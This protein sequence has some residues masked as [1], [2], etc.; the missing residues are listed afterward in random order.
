MA[1]KLATAFVDFVARMS[2]FDKGIKEV[3][4]D[5]SRFMSRFQALGS[6]FGISLGIG[7]AVAASY[8]FIEAA[9]E[10][11]EVETRMR[12]VLK[13]TG[14]AAGFNA[15]QILKMVGAL[16]QT[17]V[18]GDEALIGAATNLMKF[19]RVAGD[20]FERAL[21][22]STDLAATGFGSVEAASQ[23]LGRALQDPVRGVMALRRA[24]IIL[25]KSQKAQIETMVKHGRILE[26]Q[27]LILNMVADKT[28]G[29]AEAFAKTPAG[30]W[31]QLK[32]ILGD[33]AEDFGKRILPLAVQLGRVGSTIASGFLA[34]YDAIAK[35]NSVLGG[36]P[37]KL[38][39]T[40]AVL[41]QLPPLIG[42]VRVAFAALNTAMIKGALINPYTAALVILAAVLVAIYEIGKAISK[43]AIVQKMWSDTIAPIKAA[44]LK[45]STAVSKAWEQVQDKLLYA[46]ET[47]K[48][49]MSVAWQAVLIGLG[50][51][52][53]MVQR[54]T[55]IAITGFETMT[56]MLSTF[57]TMAIHGL[58]EMTADAAEWS[59][60]IVTQWQY[61]QAALYAGIGFIASAALDMLIHAFTAPF[62]IMLQ[63]AIQVFTSIPRLLEAALNGGLEGL[64]QQVQKEL[65][66]AL[67]NAVKIATDLKI[68]PG[69]EE[70]WA[71]FKRNLEALKK[72]KEDLE[73]NRKFPA[74]PD[75]EAEKK[76][77]KDKKGPVELDIKSGLQGLTD[78][79]RIVQE[80]MLKAEQDDPMADIA[81]GVG[82]VADLQGDL[83]EEFVD[84]NKNGIKLRDVATA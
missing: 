30:Q 27:A 76:K 81:K 44:W 43:I 37:A 62:Q 23:A 18:Y 82:D 65:T 74:K 80:A 22:L 69:T 70:W 31:K 83:L 7:A 39:V 24:G 78:A 32:E 55:G 63:T 6:A 42:A 50:P 57:I 26:A 45:L 34:A 14:E 12:S 15:E 17:T 5:L 13:A 53:D 2:S 20:T 48:Q 67:K 64:A 38:A 1:Y 49:A 46:W 77:K 11:I 25:D 16:Q 61:A 47:L 84:L 71:R 73:K 56:E 33:I 60:V 72:A 3:Q 19:D 59:L 35:V 51:V 40:M 28:A 9:V 79:W 10:S 58:A 29:A 52:L 4:N 41:S 36:I 68:S 21:K 54:F 66:T 75:P 8:R